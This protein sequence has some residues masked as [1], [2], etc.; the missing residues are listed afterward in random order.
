MV[1]TRGEATKDQL[2]ASWFVVP[3]LTDLMFAGDVWSDLECDDQG[4]CWQDCERAVGL[5]GDLPITLTEDKMGVSE[6]GDDRGEDGHTDHGEG[7]D[8]R[9]DGR[10]DDKGEDKGDDKDED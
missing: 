3:T 4:N 1:V 7:G 2:S 6:G 5:I 10:G 9:G 8:D